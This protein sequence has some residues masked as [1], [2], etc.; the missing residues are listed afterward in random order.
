MLVSSVDG[1][2]RLPEAW[3]S[4][5]LHIV[6]ASDFPDAIRS[7]IASTLIHCASRTLGETAKIE[8]AAPAEA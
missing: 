7:A 3:M 6:L 5:E 8:G 1:E 2:L 4:Y